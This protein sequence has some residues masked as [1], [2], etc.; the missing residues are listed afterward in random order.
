MELHSKL[1]RIVRKHI[2]DINTLPEP[3]K[4]L[5]QEINSDY[6]N[7]PPAPHAPMPDT[8]RNDHAPDEDKFGHDLLFFIDGNDIITGYS[9]QKDDL[10]LNPEIFL[11]KKF[12]ELPLGEITYLFTEGIK[13]TRET[14]SLHRLTYSGKTRL[15]RQYYEAQIIP[16]SE[17]GVI[18]II[19]NETNTVL[20]N[21]AIRFSEE[22]F[23]GLAERSFD[24]VFLLD[25]NGIFT[26]ASPSSERIAGY[27]AHE[28]MHNHFFSYLPPEEFD[29]ANRMISQILEGKNVEGFQT[30]F[31]KPDGSYASIEINASPIPEDTMI[32]GIQGI[33]RDISE[34]LDIQESLK[35]SEERFRSM[36]EYGTDVITVISRDGI[37]QYESP[38]VRR[39]LG[40]RPENVVGKNALEYVH[41][42]DIPLAVQGLNRI[43]KEPGVPITMEFRI[44]NDEG[45]WK[46]VEATGINRLDNP[47]IQGMII[48]YR[49]ISAQKESLKNLRASEERYRM[50]AESIVDI[51][52]VLEIPSMKTIYTNPAVT[53]VLGYSVEEARNMLPEQYLAPASY[54]LVAGILSEDMESLQKNGTFYQLMRKVDVEY[55]RKDGSLLW[56]E[57]SVRLLP[58]EEGSPLR[59]LGVTRDI[60]Q[61]KQA[62]NQL[63]ESEERMRILLE[64]SKDIIYSLD[65]NGNFNYISPRFEEVTGHSKQELL[66][67][68]F[69]RF[70]PP[71]HI[72][73]VTD[74]FNQG[75]QGKSTTLYECVMVFPNGDSW[76][77]EL[78]VNTIYDAS[79]SIIGRLGVARD[80]TQ[81]KQAE[82]ALRESEKLYQLLAENSA[83]LIWL[84][85]LDLNFTYLSPSLE[86]VTGYKPEELTGT[87]ALS[88]L[89]PA[90]AE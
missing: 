7:P 46:M 87:S 76:P 77:L 4:S 29:H 70:L 8:A 21:D 67:E 56:A 19:R 50:L 24:M 61:R 89:T 14:G 82:Q 16:S 22:R 85:D 43:I 18:I 66:G 25:R 30:R 78:N 73:Q 80:I 65:I 41:P 33:A 40:F 34:H 27:P 10:F 37:I 83:E 81:R 12:S 6:L 74:T 68:N 17:R 57:V 31:R 13:K 9:G 54:N 52:W 38:S 75:I 51:V 1:E 26:Y 5:L 11:H 69:T 59:I 53:T 72:R 32:C 84:S 62:E 79:G 88:I 90:S 58:R 44:L 15:G 35:K 47:S 2:D 3:V 86:W 60:S 63:K 23:R 20:Q 64:T 39:I 42:D 71:E 45:T 55:T 36:I 49:D 48:N 28:L